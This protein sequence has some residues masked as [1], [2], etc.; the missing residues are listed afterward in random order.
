M[1]Y[2]QLYLKSCILNHILFLRYGEL[3]VENQILFLPMSIWHS[4]WGEGWVGDLN[5]F[6]PKV[7]L[8][9]RLS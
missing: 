4:H 2:L 1:Q 3:S 9:H 5:G 7:L 6:S 8:Y